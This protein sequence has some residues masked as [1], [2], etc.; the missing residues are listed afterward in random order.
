MEI[1]VYRKDR[2]ANVKSMC[3]YENL[4]LSSTFLKRNLMPFRKIRTHL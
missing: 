4:F 2:I 3:I 1:S